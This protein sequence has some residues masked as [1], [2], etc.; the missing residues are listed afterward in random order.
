MNLDL[1]LQN[2]KENH[3]VQGTIIIARG[4]EIICSNISGLADV[5]TGMLCSLQTQY[6]IGSITKQFI[7]AA[8]LRV[9]FDQLSST[10][11][12]QGA[13]QK[14][15]SKYLPETHFLWQNKMPEWAKVVTL[16]HLLTHTSGIINYTALNAYNDLCSSVNPELIDV[17]E[18]FK[19]E[20]L[21]FKP[22]TRYEYCNSS[23]TLLGQVIA[24][25]SQKSLNL[26]LMNTF[27]LPLRMKETSLP[28]IGTTDTLKK[29]KSYNNL[30]R[31]YE[32]PV[33]H[34]LGPFTEV[35]YC[36]YSTNQ[37]DGGITSSALDLLK[38]NS[39]LY[40][41]KVLPFEI[42]ALMLEPYEKLPEQDE[43]FFYGYGLK[44]GDYKKGKVYSHGGR[45]PGYRSYMAYIPGL[46]LSLISF[47]NVSFNQFYNQKNCDAIRQELSHI[48]DPIEK[49]T[50]YDK[51]FSQ[52][53]PHVLAML[54]YHRLFQIKDL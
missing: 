19:I 22:G 44:C 46:D 21:K 10:T 4:N 42:L 20:P 49:Q 40:K 3:S 34:S 15:L 29:Q 6:E 33:D 7:A 27:F 30:A 2:Y 50:R 45:D 47:S 51:I 9:L 37:G 17:I 48:E 24:Q 23:Y 1:S 39:A 35:K 41:G 11:A 52:R 5:E 54:E 53:Y 13:L 28:V 16:H 14:P 31:G 18:L 25:L 8:L 36:P 12:V 43:D 26:Y 32:Y 38:W